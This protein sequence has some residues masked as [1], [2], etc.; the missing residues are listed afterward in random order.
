MVNSLD[1]ATVA[2]FGIENRSPME[3]RRKASMVFARAMSRAKRR[4]FLKRMTGRTNQ[5]RELAQVSSDERRQARRQTAVVTVPLSKVVGSE[6]RVRDFD[7]EF[8]PVGEHNRDRW[9]GIAAARNR[10]TVLPPVEL[11]QV[12][13][14]YYIRDGH[15]RVSVAKAYGQAAIEA[16]ILTV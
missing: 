15:H 3:A 6:G 4:T 14:D 5:L 10:G 2:H 12:G 9:V 16:Q 11:I 1:M 7:S 13:D 8:D